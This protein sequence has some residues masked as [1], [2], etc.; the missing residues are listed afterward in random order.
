LFLLVPI[1]RFVFYIKVYVDLAVRFG[2]AKKFWWWK[3]FPFMYQCKL[4]LSHALFDNGKYGLEDDFVSRMFNISYSSEKSSYSNGQVTIRTE[5]KEEQTIYDESKSICSKCGTPHFGWE[6]TCKKCGNSLIEK[7]SNILEKEQNT[8]VDAV[9]HNNVKS[10]ET[11][12]NAK[13]QKTEKTIVVTDK[14][15]NENFEKQPTVTKKKKKS[16]LYLILSL[17]VLLLVGAIS[18]YV[19]VGNDGTGGLEIENGVLISVGSCNKSEIVIPKSVNSIGKNA[20]SVYT[21]LTSI[22]IPNSVTSIE[23]HAFSGC[24]NLKSLILPNSIRSIGKYTFSGVKCNI[25]YKGTIAQ[26]NA[27]NKSINWNKGFTNNIICTD[28]TIEL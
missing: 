7:S 6:T 15:R 10:G 16:K 13:I 3:V 4:G 17:V 18:A 19:L 24:S 21:N 25:I 12:P 5:T 20:F 11:V 26:W 23:D 9:G 14:L 28:G 27:I 2:K 8:D 22:T 1:Y